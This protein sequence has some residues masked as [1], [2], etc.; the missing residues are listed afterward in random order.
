MTVQLLVMAKAPIPGRVKTRL[1]PPWTP[2]QAATIA[3]AALDDTLT[4]GLA[5]PAVRHTLVLD[6][7]DDAATT[8]QRPGGWRA[9]TQHGDGLGSRLGN[10]FTDTAIVGVTS[11]LIGMD[12]PQVTPELLATVAA[13]MTDG[14]D[15]VLAPALDGGWWAL[16]LREPVYAR[17]LADVPMSTA[18]TGADTVAALRKL[19]ATVAIG[20]ALGDVDTAANAVEIAALCPGGMFAAAVTHALDGAA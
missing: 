16:A 19:G 3:A 9:V 10:A 2:E 6:P 4:A 8:W 14:T 20:P 12:T 13:G 5:F 15:A 18:T 17:V 11:L 1:C 7:G